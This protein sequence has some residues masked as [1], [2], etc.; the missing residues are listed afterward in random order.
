MRVTDGSRGFRSGDG[1]V[2]V[3]RINIANGAWTISSRPTPVAF[4]ERRRPEP[5][6]TRAWIRRIKAIRIAPTASSTS[7]PSTRSRSGRWWAQRPRSARLGSCRCSKGGSFV[8]EIAER[9]LTLMF[10]NSDRQAGFLF[11]IRQGRPICA[12]VLNAVPFKVRLKALHLAGA[13][14]KG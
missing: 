11:P 7:T 6:A 4:G 8:D 2:S 12:Y 10:A 9:I 13:G 5:P 3:R 14:L 1:V